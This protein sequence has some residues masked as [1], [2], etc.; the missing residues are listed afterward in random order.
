MTSETTRIPIT[1]REF[2]RKPYVFLLYL[3]GV[4]F[5]TYLSLEFSNLQNPELQ[6]WFL[7]LTTATF[8]SYL[9]AIVVDK[10]FRDKEHRERERVRRT[11]L[12]RLQAPLNRHLS[13]LAGWYVAASDEESFDKPDSLRTLLEDDFPETVMYLDFESSAPTTNPDQDWLNYSANQ[14]LSFNQEIDEVLAKYGVYLDSDMVESL[15]LVA[16]STMSSAIISCERTRP[17]IRRWREETEIDRPSSGNHLSLVLNEQV[18][19]HVENV[20]RL[21]QHYENRELEFELSGTSPLNESMTPSVGSA[22][23]EVMIQK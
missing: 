21:M 1:L 7:S 19:D 14:L 2:F 13:L 12:R 23:L 5:S 6:P 11:A 16:N 22:R 3:S 20:L 8:G 4:C 17:E 18:E 9:T 10:S 15:E